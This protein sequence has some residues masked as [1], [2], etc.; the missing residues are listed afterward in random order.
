MG[1]GGHRGHGGHDRGRRASGSVAVALALV[2]S[3]CGT[4][5]SRPAATPDPEAVQAGP[6]AGGATDGQGDSEV[7]DAIV[8]PQP[9]QVDVV[10]VPWDVVEHVEGTVLGLQ[11]RSR[12]AP[13]EVLDRVE[14]EET[15]EQVTATLFQGRD[16]DVAADD[17]ACLDA[18]VR[19]LR[20]EIPLEEWVDCRTFVDGADGRSTGC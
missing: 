1:H 15:A 3:A 16:P 4:S 8:V 11:F 12:G 18:P 17:P 6:D 9:G 5:A 20:V 19:T 14:I 7:P 2:L 13:C 10:P